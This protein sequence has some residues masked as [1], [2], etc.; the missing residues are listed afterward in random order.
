M[1]FCC[2]EYLFLVVGVGVAWCVLFD[3]CCS[4]VVVRFV[5]C[6]VLVVADGCPLY[7]V[8]SSFSVECCVLVLCCVCCL[9]VVAGC[10]L[11]VARFLVRRLALFVVCCLLFVV[12]R[13]RN[14]AFCFFG[15]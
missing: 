3:A 14:V 7:V 10:S 9:M 12:A 15:L 4:L 6:V 8:H 2:V 5:L 1:S 11:F 13:G